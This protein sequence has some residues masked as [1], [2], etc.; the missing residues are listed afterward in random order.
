VLGGLGAQCLP[1]LDKGAP[2][3]DLVKWF[4]REIKSL[5]ET[6]TQLNK[7]FV[8]LALAGMLRMLHDSS[9]EHLPML[10]SLA[11]LSDASLLDEI[12]TEVQ[13]IAE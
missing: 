8:T 13:E 4:E 12:P 1:Y 3:G 7:S 6:F 5:L 2:L 9:C 10:S 11:S